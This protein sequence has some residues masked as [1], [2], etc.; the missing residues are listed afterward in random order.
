MSSMEISRRTLLLAGATAPFLPTGLSQNRSHILYA[1]AYRQRRTQTFGIAFLD[2]DG[3]LVH[4]RELPERGHDIVQNLAANEISVISRRPG[5]KISVLDIYSGE[6]KQVVNASA[7]R[8]YYGHGCYN[9][10]GEL[11]FVTEN[12]YETGH[13]KIGLYDATDKYSKIGE[14]PS[15]G[16]GPHEILLMPDG[17]TLAVANGGVQTHPDAPRIKMNVATM[18]SS[19]AFINADTGKLVGKHECKS[20]LNQQASIRHIAVNASGLLALAIQWEGDVSA[21]PPLVATC[22]LNQGISYVS[23]PSEVLKSM[24]LYAGS[25]SFDGN[26]DRF[27]VTSPRGSVAT[28]WSNSGEYISSHILQDVCG[29]TSLHT[30][31]GFLLSDGTGALSGISKERLQPKNSLSDIEWDNHLLKMKV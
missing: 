16:I 10:S 25:V 11:L 14:I 20:P 27:C 15:F 26:G 12:D 3:S 9:A 13:G 24:R 4:S 1:G 5:T 17:K 6:L 23:A 31:T 29:V 30:P 21:S 7:G 18:K 2:Q 22:T 28:V 19:I 8:H